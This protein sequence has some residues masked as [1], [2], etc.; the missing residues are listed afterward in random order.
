MEW[1]TYALP[2]FL[3]VALIVTTSVG[4]R[5]T[6]VINKDCPLFK[7]FNR[8]RGKVSNINKFLTRERYYKK[9]ITQLD[10]E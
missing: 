6:F 2:S 10:G 5:T 8:N 1:G 7:H 4:K 9:G 3:L